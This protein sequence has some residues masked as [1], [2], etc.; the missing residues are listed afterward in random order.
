MKQLNT[1]SSIDSHR[2]KLRVLVVDDNRLARSLIGY[3]LG[4]LNFECVHAQDGVEALAQLKENQF[5]LIVL[6]WKMPHCNGWETLQ[7]G[8]TLLK[9]KSQT[10]APIPVVIYT[11]ATLAELDI[12]SCAELWDISLTSREVGHEAFDQI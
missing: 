7:R 9:Q 10:E 3:F 8:E 12:P 5:D 2:K 6:D 4:S 1:L 11:D